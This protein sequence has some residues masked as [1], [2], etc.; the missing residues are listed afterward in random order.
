MRSLGPEA[1]LMQPHAIVGD[2]SPRLCGRGSGPALGLR[3]A[4]NSRQRTRRHRTSPQVFVTQGP[5]PADREHS[6]REP[7]MQF[8]VCLL[9]PP[10]GDPGSWW[11][12]PHLSPQLHGST[13]VYGYCILQVDRFLYSVRVGIVQHLLYYLVIYSAVRHVWLNVG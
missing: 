12:A 2:T 5:S 4:A 13:Y 3:E 9:P 8:C 1:T 6:L 11:R 10:C 7:S